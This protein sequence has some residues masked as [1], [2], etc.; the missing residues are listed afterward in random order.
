MSEKA[1]TAPPAPSCRQAGQTLYLSGQVGA[2]AN[3]VPVAGTFKDE[4]RQVFRNVESVLQSEGAFLH[5]IVHVRTYLADFAD[6]TEF[7]EVWAEVFPDNPPARATVQAGL[8]PPFR[9]EAEVVAHLGQDR[10]R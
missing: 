6:F 4:V 5:E 2:D 9:I 7:N 1:V 10:Q 3:W 8:H